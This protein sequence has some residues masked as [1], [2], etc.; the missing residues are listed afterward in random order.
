[1]RT[2]HRWPHLLLLC[3]ALVM[4]TGWDDDW[5]WGDGDSDTE[6]SDSEGCGSSKDRDQPRPP[7]PPPP[8]IVITRSCTV[9]VEG[10]EPHDLTCRWT[11]RTTSSSGTE[12]LLEA[13]DRW[14]VDQGEVDF[15]ARAQLTRYAGLEKDFPYSWNRELDVLN[16]AVA[17]YPPHQ[18]D[19]AHP[20]AI[21]HART[22]VR[23]RINANDWATLRL[24]DLVVP[25]GRL[26]GSMPNVDANGEAPDPEHA[27]GFQL[28]F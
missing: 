25:H 16:G 14:L 1:M 5:D 11:S 6:E 26:Y 2:R 4:T 9:T 23:F 21:P 15:D 13:S 24:S 18:A 20:P 12:Y 17:F 22:T 8:P 27:L 28:D 10:Y 7:P 19:A 3:L